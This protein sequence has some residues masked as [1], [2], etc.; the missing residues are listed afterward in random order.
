[1]DVLMKGKDLFTIGMAL[2]FEQEKDSKMIRYRTK[3]CDITDKQIE[4][5]P[6][7]NTENSREAIL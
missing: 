5:E 6:L 2:F 3:I 1:M 4:I 7:M